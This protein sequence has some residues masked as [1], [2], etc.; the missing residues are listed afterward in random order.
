MLLLDIVNK[1]VHADVSCDT[2]TAFEAHFFS[3]LIILF[4]LVTG[5]LLCA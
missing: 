3:A 5:L 4:D 1:N 2:T